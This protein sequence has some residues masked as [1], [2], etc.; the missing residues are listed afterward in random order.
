MLIK[1][2]KLYLTYPSKDGEER[3]CNSRL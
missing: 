3:E 1:S 2:N